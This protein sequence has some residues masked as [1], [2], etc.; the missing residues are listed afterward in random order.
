[1]KKNFQEDGVKTSRNSLQASVMAGD[2]DAFVAA[3]AGTAL[4]GK[5]TQVQ[6]DSVVVKFKK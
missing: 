3:I 4:E 5:I 6:F 2:Y 1:M